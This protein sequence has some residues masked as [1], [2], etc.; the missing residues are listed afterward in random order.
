M[1]RAVEFPPMLPC[2]G[3]AYA[4]GPS[5]A[6]RGPSGRKELVVSDAAGVFY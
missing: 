3:C 6:N 4:A 5:F 2:I 1:E